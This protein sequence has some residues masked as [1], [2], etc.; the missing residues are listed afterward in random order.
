M[1]LAVGR[2]IQAFASV[3]MAFGYCFASMM[4]PGDRICSLAILDASRHV[5]TKL[6]IIDR[7]AP[8]ALAGER[9]TTWKNLS[10]RIRKRSGMRN[11]LAHWTV[12]HWPGMSSVEDIKRV[13][14]RLVPPMS[15]FDHW[16]VMWGGETD[17]RPVTLD[18]IDVFTAKCI[19]LTTDL[20][21]FS[22][23]LDSEAEDRAKKRTKVVDGQV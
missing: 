15:S 22:I 5:E 2:G 17:A 13:G 7:V 8:I 19:E 23:L 10:S 1:L 20:L 9:L 16:A 6:R 21:N 18:E 12:S 3:E 14:V 4:E 11:K